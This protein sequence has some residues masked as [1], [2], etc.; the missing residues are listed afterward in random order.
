MA[1]LIA[2]MVPML[3][4]GGLITGWLA[5]ASSRAWGYGFISD[6]ILGLAGSLIVGAFVWLLIWRDA[7]MTTMLL[8]GCI[9]AALAIIAQRGVWPSTRA[10][11]EG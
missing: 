2:Q 1:E 6:M 5:E 10:T 4:L 8:V 3:V 9:G 7:G 11:A